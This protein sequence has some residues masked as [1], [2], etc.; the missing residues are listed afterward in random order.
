[1]IDGILDLRVASRGIAASGVVMLDLAAA[2]G[3]LLPEWSPGAHIDL[4]L[5]NGLVRQYS[6]CGQVQDR[7]TWRVA[8]LRE[9]EGRGGSACVHDDLAVGAVIPSGG[10]R[11]HFVYTP[12]ARSL[13]I[14]GGIGITPLL[15]MI[16][17]A[18][19][20][21]TDWTLVYGGRTLEAMAFRE[22]L[23]THGDRV[24]FFPQDEHGLIPVRELLRAEPLETEVYCCGPE[25]LLAAVEAHHAQRH[26]ARLHVERFGPPER[27]P[28]AVDT[29]FTVTLRRSRRSL[30]VPAD[31]SILQTLEEAGV[32][33][34]SS[35][36]EGSCGTCETP[37]SAGRPDHRDSV[38]TPAEREAGQTMMICVSR[39]LTADLVLD[40]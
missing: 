3:R 21:G 16:E 1:M 9:P 19:V 12:A 23:Q 37:V 36:E 8:V 25:G 18:G 33:V 38:L 13:F 30:T 4:H 28:G 32:E 5:P 26:P 17:A 24:Q 29:E 35:C 34:D 20:D 11:N 31:R 27:D 40:L 2:D 7:M 15:P 6:L 10:P 39:S 22:Q 14:A